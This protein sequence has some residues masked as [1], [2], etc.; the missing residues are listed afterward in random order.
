MIKFPM[1]HSVVFID[2]LQ[3][4]FFVMIISTISGTLWAGVCD[5]FVDF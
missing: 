4:M 2:V 1:G 3:V 5:F